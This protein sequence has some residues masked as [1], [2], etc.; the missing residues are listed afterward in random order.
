M[1]GVLEN[2]RKG[3]ERLEK[4]REEDQ[5]ELEKKRA[6]DAPL[7][8]EAAAKRAHPGDSVFKQTMQTINRLSSSYRR[9]YWK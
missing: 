2:L 7:V 8:G 9:S 1:D 4:K 5:E 6:R 3:I